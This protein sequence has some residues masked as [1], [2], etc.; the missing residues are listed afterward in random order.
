MKWKKTINYKKKDSLTKIAG[1]GALWQFGGGALSSVI[2]LGASAVLARFLNP[3]DF[4]ILGMGITAMG[5][6]AYLGNMGIGA[7]IISK[8][9]LDQRDLSTGFWILLINRIILYSIVF[10][11]APYV[12]WFFNEPRV[13]PVFKVVTLVF[14]LSALDNIPRSLMIRRMQYR[15]LCIVNLFGG[16]VETTM[17]ILLVVYTDLRYWC[18]VI[19]MLTSYV[20]SLV[21]LYLRTKWFPRPNFSV[22]SFVYFK[23]FIISGLGSSAVLYLKQN[24]DYLLVGRWFGATTLGL[25][26]YAY[27]IPHMFVDRLISPMMGVLFPSLARLQ[28]DKESSAAGFLKAVRLIG[29][30]TIPCL[31]ML[32][33]TADDLVPLLWGNKWLAI[34]T[35]LKILSFSAVVMAILIPVNHI[36]WV[37]KRPDMVFKNNLVTF[38]STFL[39]VGIGGFYLGINGVALGILFGTIPGIYFLII[40]CRMIELPS[41]LF[42]KAL[43][44]LLF[45]SF[46][47]SLS[48]FLVGN[49]ISLNHLILLVLKAIFGLVVF[50]TSLY[51]ISKDIFRDLFFVLS[52]VL[53]LNKN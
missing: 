31:F 43:L 21:L 22:E 52:E 28:K 44:P 50:I 6:V 40:G 48:I 19:A 12:A 24:I 26:E 30:I 37:Y 35:P 46:L 25:Y 4:G 39:S 53:G 2:R 11:L 23:R 18:L 42:F 29:L 32:A 51:L 41:K 9:D 1:R 5:V 27:K 3:E 8:Q 45:C 34:I 14:L 16:I 10:S 17:A 49:I 15:D 36:F 38:L 47:A 33:S 7:A 13:T 20:S